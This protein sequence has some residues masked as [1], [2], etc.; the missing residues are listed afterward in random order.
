MHTA[1]LGKSQSLAFKVGGGPKDHGQSR[2]LRL[3][4]QR[5]DKL[6]AIHR[7]HQDI[8]EYDRRGTQASK[9]QPFLIILGFRDLMA[10]AF[11]YGSQV[12][13]A[14]SVA[15]N[16]QNLSHQGSLFSRRAFI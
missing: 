15:F 6:I 9:L 1:F 16:D 8:N 12:F 14:G 7:S 13:P 2:L 5:A 4:A 10:E 11:E 3:A